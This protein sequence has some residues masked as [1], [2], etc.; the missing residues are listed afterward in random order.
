MNFLLISG[1]YPPDIGGPASFIPEFGRFIKQSGC[2]VEVITLSPT[3]D[4][5]LDEDFGRVTRVKRDTTRLF[6]FIKV[7]LQIYKRSLKSEIIFANGLYE[8]CAVAS[9]F[10]KKKILFKIVGDPI[11][12]RSRNSGKSSLNFVDYEPNQLSIKLKFERVFFYWSLRKADKITCPGKELAKSIEKNYGVKNI[13][14]IEN[15]VDTVPPAKK[16]EYQFDV[17]SV[18]RL[19]EWKRIDLL[20]RAAART[21][22]SLAVIGEGPKEIELKQL[23]KKLNAK[24]FFFGSMP[25]AEVIRNLRQSRIYALVS[26]YEG[27]SF[28]LLEALSVGKRILVSNIDAN[29]NLFEGTVFA[30]IVNPEI[31]EKIDE[32]IK[33]LK[34]DSKLNIKR[35]KEAIELVNRKYSSKSQLKKMFDLA[36]S[37][38]DAK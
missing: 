33:L 29:K 19:V 13:H 25:K 38:L 9:L 35:E 8:E 27:L 15:G 26:S 34:P 30:A 5:V 6:R 32:A 18:S 2:E 10:S 28:S 1:I 31:P 36:L 37:T 14:V 21:N 11:W 3:K 17:I 16:L 24:V 22:T 4:E 20:I 7:T 12:E 23:A